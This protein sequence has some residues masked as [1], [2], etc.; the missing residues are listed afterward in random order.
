MRLP[1]LGE[2]LADGNETSVDV[3]YV[4]DT[5]KFSGN[6]FAIHNSGE[7]EGSGPVG[8]NCTALGC[9]NS[10]RGFKQ[11]VIVQGIYFVNKVA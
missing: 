9:S 7:L 6:L 3:R 2:E 10:T 5:L 11:D 1:A 4:I 8:V